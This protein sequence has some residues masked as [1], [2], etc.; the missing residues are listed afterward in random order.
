[1]TAAS[2]LEEPRRGWL[3]PVAA[4]GILLPAALA[5][6]LLS[7]PG[8]PFAAWAVAPVALFTFALGRAIEG[9]RRGPVPAAAGAV[10]REGVFGFLLLDSAV[11]ALRGS[12]LPAGAALVLWAGLR[13]ALAGRRS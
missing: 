1:M 2:L 8:H 4:A 5:F 3:V 13:A 11:L 9:T 7:V 12:P 10:V 6:P